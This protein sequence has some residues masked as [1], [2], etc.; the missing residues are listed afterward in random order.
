MQ[1]QI[2]TLYCQPK[3]VGEFMLLPSQ[4]L[5]LPR[6]KALSFLSAVYILMY[7]VLVQCSSHH[8]QRMLLLS[9]YTEYYIQLH[10][11]KILR[12]LIMR[13]PTLVDKS[14]I[15]Y[16]CLRFKEHCWTR[17]G[18]VGR[19]REQQCLLWDSISPYDTEVVFMK[20]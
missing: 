5:P 3:I 4:T 14:V 1:Y 13:C 8:H 12:R 16:L 11:V 9:A 10:L 2:Y 7:L 15:E 19:A 6:L 17:G 18:N 20:S